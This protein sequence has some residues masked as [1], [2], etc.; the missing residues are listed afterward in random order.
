MAFKF[1][2]RLPFGN[3]QANSDGMNSKLTDW[4]SQSKIIAL[5]A[6]NGKESS[7]GEIHR[8]GQEKREYNDSNKYGSFADQYGHQKH[9]I[10]SAI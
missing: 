9:P 1:H 3:V 4:I 10:D 2:R 6:E 5:R 7:F 8:F